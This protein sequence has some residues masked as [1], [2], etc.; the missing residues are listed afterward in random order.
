MTRQ[1]KSYYLALAFVLLAAVAIFGT[2]LYRMNQR[3]LPHVEVDRNRWPVR[4]IDVSKHNGEID[5]AKVAADSIDFVYI[6]ATEG[7]EYEDPNFALNYV[8]ARRAGLAVGAYHFFRFD[9]SGLKQAYNLMETLHNVRLDL[10]VAIDVEEWSNAPATSTDDIIDR[11]EVM[12]ER[13]EAS[14]YDIIIY[15]NKS[16]YSRFIKQRLGRL[17]VWICSFTDPPLADEWLLWQHSHR[18]R[19]NGIRG[20][21]DLNTFNG[22]HTRFNNF[23]VTAPIAPF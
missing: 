8:R 10:P 21:V 17:P 4:G 16:G 11:L 14:G 15:T 20:S 19:V 5:F 23:R 22:D 2:V 3:R 9:V 7:A 18:G 13:L 1:N 6:K 12:V